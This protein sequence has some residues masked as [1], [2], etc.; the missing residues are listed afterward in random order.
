MIGEARQRLSF[1]R[2]GYLCNNPGV[3]RLAPARLLALAVLTAWLLPGAGALAAGVHMLTHDGHAGELASHLALGVVHGHA[4]GIAEPTHDHPA[5]CYGVAQALL[6][7]TTASVLA[8]V[9][10]SALPA[11]SLSSTPANPPRRPPPEPLFYSHCA[12]L[13]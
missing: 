3:F 2:D 11:A 4:H 12:L 6:A 9:A 13:L 5:A 7:W 10:G 1:D 8:A